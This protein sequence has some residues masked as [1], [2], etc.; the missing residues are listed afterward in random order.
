MKS[1]SAPTSAADAIA[2]KPDDEKPGALTEPELP[3]GA[4][5]GADGSGALERTMGTELCPRA[6]NDV[7]APWL[8]VAPLALDS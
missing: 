7:A 3:E 6:C 1:T 5:D 8:F 2:A 4:E